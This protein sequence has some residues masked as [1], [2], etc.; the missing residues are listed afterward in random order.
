MEYKL[1]KQMVKLLQTVKITNVFNSQYL[2]MNLMKFPAK[3][4]V[5]IK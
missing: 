3:A 5:H 1:L 2:S 4:L